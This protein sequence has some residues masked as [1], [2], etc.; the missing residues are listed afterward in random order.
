M[1]AGKAYMDDPLFGTDPQPKHMRNLYKGAED[2][3]GV[4]Y[5]SRSPNHAFYVAAK[6]LGGNS[7]ERASKVWYGRMTSR[8]IL[9]DCDLTTF[10]AVTVD[11]AEK[12]LMMQR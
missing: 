11:I 2:G 7:W 1:K 12:K 10:A 9:P 4:Y 6:S 8:R 3:S 5:N